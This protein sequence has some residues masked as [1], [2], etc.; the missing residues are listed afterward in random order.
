MKTQV[1]FIIFIV[2]VVV[3]VGGFGVYS[4]FKS[5]PPSKLDGF[6]QCLKT[7]GAEFYGA[8]WCPHCQEQKAEGTSQN[9]RLTLQ[10]LADKTQCVLPQ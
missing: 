8:F 7:G 5:A 4:A 10:T 6:A 9:G 1:K 2:A 3:L